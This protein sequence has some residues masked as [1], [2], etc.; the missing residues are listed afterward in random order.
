[1]AAPP[2]RDKVVMKCLE[3]VWE[4]LDGY[5]RCQ[6]QGTVRLTVTLLEHPE[7]P[8]RTLQQQME[9]IQPT[10]TPYLLAEPVQVV[11]VSSSEED[12]EEDLEGE[13]DEP[14]SEPEVEIHDIPEIDEEP[15]IDLDSPE[16]FIPVPEV[17]STE[18]SGL[19]WL[20]ESDD[21]LGG[22]D[23]P[24]LTPTV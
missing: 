10:P 17:E 3:G 6:F 18:E 8:T 14:H 19:G 7:H 4:T 12:P 21:S 1:M 22:D 13:P 2:I 5:K 20:V 23:H 11:D 24:K 9:S 15:I 16:E